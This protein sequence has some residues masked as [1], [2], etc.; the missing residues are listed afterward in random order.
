MTVINTSPAIHLHAVLDGGLGSL[1][2][3]IGGIVIP[4][5]V[6]QELVAGGD[7]DDTWLQIQGKNGIIVRPA[8]VIIHPLLGPQIDRGEAAVIQT[9]LDEAH[10][11]VILDDLKARRIAKL[12]G[13][14]VTGTLGILV[15]AKRAGQLTSVRDTIAALDQ[16]GMWIAPDV[17]AKAI[18]LAGENAQST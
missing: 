14:N 8:P 13:L 16:R 17:A 7:K 9:A 2:A 5:E 1:P 3:L 11:T 18:Q 6:A 4:W 10:D 12:L 15:Q